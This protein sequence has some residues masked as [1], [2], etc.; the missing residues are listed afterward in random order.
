MTITGRDGLGMPST[1]QMQRIAGRIE[2]L[3]QALPARHDA[4]SWGVCHVDC[5]F[6]SG[7]LIVR[8]LDVVLPNGFHVARDDGRLRVDLRPLPPGDHAVYLTV[9]LLPPD[10]SNRFL[11]SEPRVTAD[12]MLGEDGLELPRTRTR[13]ALVTTPPASQ[14]TSLPLLRVTVRR[15]REREQ[16]DGWSEATTFVPPTL[17]VLPGSVLGQKCRAIADRLHRE[18]DALTARANTGP[19]TLA[20]VEARAQLGPL[21]SALNAFEVLLDGQPHPFTLYVELCRLAG[22]VAVLRR[23]GVP[24]PPPYDHNDAW[25][26]FDA[27]ARSFAAAPTGRVLKF[28]FQPE[29]HTFRLPPDDAWMNAAAPGASARTILAVES[30]SPPELARRWGENCVIG[31]RSRM[32]LLESRRILGSPRTTVQHVEGIPVDRRTVLFALTPDEHMRLPHEDLL[33]LGN[34]RELT[35]KALHLY[36]VLG[37]RGNA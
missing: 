15:N 9:T 34:T 26:V 30:D 31:S 19:P 1:A 2:G 29:G 33:V 6:E 7:I 23:N 32:P 36:V 24:K 22:A 11:S 3:I 20:T 13:M 25:T 27:V 5:V 12:E 10:E 8:K 16:R 18:A 37:E 21:V 4:F 28:T 35:P 14:D 17:K